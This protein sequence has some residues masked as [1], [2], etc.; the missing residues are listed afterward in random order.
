MNPVRVPNWCYGMGWLDIE[1]QGGGERRTIR[2]VNT[3]EA[4]RSDTVRNVE[5]KSGQQPTI[6]SDGGLTDQTRRIIVTFIGDPEAGRFPSD[7]ASFRQSRRAVFC[8]Q[9]PA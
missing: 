1:F 4:D 6:L 7:V 5:W 3:G 9:P 2:F 8:I